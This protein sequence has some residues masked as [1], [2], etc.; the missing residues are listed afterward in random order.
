MI[1]FIYKWL[2]SSAISD[3][4]AI[5]GFIRRH[6]QNCPECLAY[7]KDSL[8][9]TAML[10][11]QAAQS[12]H[13]HD[14]PLPADKINASTQWRQITFKAAAMVAVFAAAALILSI[15]TKPSTTQ[16]QLDYFDYN[17]SVI[18]NITELEHPFL[19]AQDLPLTQEPY[20]GFEVFLR[21]AFGL[22][23]D[24]LSADADNDAG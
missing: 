20:E 18:L 11:A 6:V 23:I 19:F 8:R 1:C 16:E 14:S 3:D 4:K 13:L 12:M 17:T 7:Y 21:S 22:V 15:H 24:G 9:L 5:S 2:I 10:R